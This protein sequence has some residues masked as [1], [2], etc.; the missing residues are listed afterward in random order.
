MKK[1]LSIILSIIM[2]FSAFAVMP[3][4][5]LADGYDNKD[6]LEEYAQYS[7]QES[8]FGCTYTSE[9]TAFKVWAPEADSMQV[10]LYKTGTD[11]EPGAGVIGTENMTYDSASGRSE[12]RRV[13]KEC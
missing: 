13:G 4:H 2:A 3:Y 5:A 1:T 10:K 8:G 7:A 11:S 6:Y 9:A 12:E